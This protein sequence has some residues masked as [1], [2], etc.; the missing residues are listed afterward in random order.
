MKKVIVKILKYCIT[1]LSLIFIFNV[2]LYLVCLFDSNILKKNVEESSAILKNE[3]YRYKLSNIFNI[4]NDTYTDALIINEVYSIESEKPYLSYMKVKRNFKRG[5]SNFEAPEEGGEGFTVNYNEFENKEIY[6]ADAIGELEDF[7]NGKIHYSTIYARYWHGYLLIYRP[8]LILFNILQIK[9]L[10]FALYLILFVYFLYLIHKQYRKN[11]CV[12]FGLSLVCSGYFSASYSLSSSPVFLTMMIS[13]IY[14]LKKIN[15]IENFSFFIFIVGCITSFIDYLTVPLISFGIPCA[16]YL[17][18]MYD[19]NVD[20]KYCTIFLIK[21]SIVWAIGF[22]LTWFFK[23]MQ[24]DLTIND[25]NNMLNIG[26]SQILFRTQRVNEAWGVD[27]NYFSVIYEII[28]KSTLYILLSIII[29]MVLNKFKLTSNKINKKIVPIFLLAL[30]PIAWYIVLAN[31]TI[32]HD[33]YTYRNSLIFMLCILLCVYKIF[34]A[35]EVE[36]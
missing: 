17:L 8:L 27:I 28:S 11:I 35:N 12:I 29:I 7:L 18:K 15:K 33:F 14:L 6:S 22:I 30:Y 20:W 25:G 34:F 31:H 16:I 32:M 26:F 36:K 1:F 13:C 24:F 3:G 10:L 9:H 5:I 23:W 21:N 2:L 4:K 19:D